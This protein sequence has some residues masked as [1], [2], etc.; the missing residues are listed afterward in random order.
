[1]LEFHLILIVIEVI[2]LMVGVWLYMKVQGEKKADPKEAAQ[3]RQGN[4]A[5]YMKSK[6]WEGLRKQA[7]MRAGH[8]CELCDAD[9]EAIHRIKYPQNIADD[10]VGNLLVVCGKCYAKLHGVP[11][12]AVSE[13]QA[14]IMA[15][16]AQ[17]VES[18]QDLFEPPPKIYAKQLELFPQNDQK[19]Q[20]LFSEEVVCGGRAFFF[21]VHQISSQ[22]RRLTIT[23][24]RKSRQKRYGDYRITV[25]EEDLIRFRDAFTETMGYLRVAPAPTS[26]KKELFTGRALCENCTYFFDV[27]LAVNGRK[28]LKITESKKVNAHAWERKHIMTFEEDFEPFAA[29]LGRAMTIL[30]LQMN[31]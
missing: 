17:E 31:I 14:Q 15:Q 24:D 29:G 4:D 6:R 18:H 1:M 13:E 30:G 19:H 21:D 10:H 11:H 20:K 23:E 8:Q 16:E 28:Y 26:D 5:D 25:P 22:E 9:Y 7:L 3:P 27:K 12:Q 2:L